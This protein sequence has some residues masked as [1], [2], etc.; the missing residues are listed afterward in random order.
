MN[1]YRNTDVIKY[2]KVI[3]PD[4]YSGTKLALDVRLKKKWSIGNSPLNDVY[5][6]WLDY[7]VKNDHCFI[8][9]KQSIWK[10]HPYNGETFKNGISISNNSDLKIN[11]IIT[12][13]RNA[14]TQLKYLEESRS[15]FNENYHSG[16][17]ISS[18]PVAKKQ[19]I[20]SKIN[21]RQRKNG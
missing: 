7:E 9:F 18:S 3:S 16:T 5:I 15:L 4:G 19:N 10:I 20:V 13:G 8:E 12:L 1:I 2:L 6:K 21:I 17:I 11:D 14:I